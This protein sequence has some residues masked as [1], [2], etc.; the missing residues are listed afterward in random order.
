MARRWRRDGAVLVAGT[1]AGRGGAIRLREHALEAM[2]WPR[3]VGDKDQGILRDF[4][5]L[6]A[7]KRAVERWLDQHAARPKRKRGGR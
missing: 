7:A 4:Q 5:T 1:Y 2:T 3:F 6:S